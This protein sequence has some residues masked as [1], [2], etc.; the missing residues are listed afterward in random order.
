M[1]PNPVK[2]CANSTIRD[3]VKTPNSYT[4]HL[5]DARELTCR[6]HTHRAM[7]RSHASRHAAVKRI[8]PW[9]G[10]MHRTVGLS[11]ERE[12]TTREYSA[13]VYVRRGPAEDMGRVGG[14]SVRCG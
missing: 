14:W 3:P 13:G 1:L 6:R 5:G 8:A 2:V 9:G 7:Q 11:S 12:E 10:H 4:S